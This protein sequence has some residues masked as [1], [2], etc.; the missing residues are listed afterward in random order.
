MMN[1]PKIMAL[2][3]TIE[4]ARAALHGVPRSVHKQHLFSSAQI[5]DISALLDDLEVGIRRDV[6][7]ENWDVLINLDQDNPIN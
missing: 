7:G 1:D 4:R 5:A 6:L 2:L 3:E